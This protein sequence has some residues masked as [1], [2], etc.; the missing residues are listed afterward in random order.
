MIFNVTSL[1]T[2][3]N[4]IRKISNLMILFKL[5]INIFIRIN[6]SHKTKTP[7]KRRLD[8]PP[9]VVQSGCAWAQGAAHSDLFRWPPNFTNISTTPP[10]TILILG[11]EANSKFKGLNF[12]FQA[13]DSPSSGDQWRWNL[14]E[15]D[16]S[17]E[18]YRTQ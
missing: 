11:T 10:G 14:Q 15:N 18:G 17:G 12:T 4:S 8:G 13:V 3:Q 6:I 9:R 2:N 1:I 7:L 16:H 5:H